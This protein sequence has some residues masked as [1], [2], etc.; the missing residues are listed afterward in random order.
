M[1]MIC[2]LEHR[3][4]RQ[5]NNPFVYVLPTLLMSKIA[6]QT[7]CSFDPFCHCKV[8]I[9]SHERFKKKLAATF[10]KHHAVATVTLQV[11]DSS[12]RRRLSPLHFL[13]LLF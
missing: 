5:P 1:A 2:T 11:T 7:A 9:A 13:Q 10:P 4:S 8:G 6:W 3:S 12:P